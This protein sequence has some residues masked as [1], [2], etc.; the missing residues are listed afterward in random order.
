MSTLDGGEGDPGIA[1]AV[2]DSLSE[3]CQV[4]GFDWSYLYVNE[5]AARH[6]RTTRAELIGKTMM[7]C[8]PGIEEMPVFDL[9]RRCMSGRTA[10]R[11]DEEFSFADGSKRWFDLRVV[12]VP[13]GIYIL[14]IDVTARRQAELSLVE[15]ERM[16][17]GLFEAAPDGILVAERD[18]TILMANPE[19]E[20]MFAS[21]EGSLVGRS[22]ESLLPVPS[23][24]AHAEHR[25]QFFASPQMRRMRKGR[26]LA[27][28]RGDGSSFP[29]NV[30]LG[31]YSYQSRD[32]AVAVVRDI[33]EQKQLAEK[34]QRSEEQL[35]QAQKMEAIG[36]LA[37]GV[38]HDFNNLLSVILSYSYLLARDL[39]ADD[40][41]R[42][43]LDEIRRAGERAADLTRQLLAFGRKQILEPRPISLHGI[44]ASI[45][46]M[47]RRILGEDI[48]LTVI[49]DPAPAIVNV[50]PGQMEQV[51]LNLAVNSR[52]AMPQGGK[53]TIEIRSVELDREYIAGHFGI[54]PGPHVMLAV[55]D[56]GT[57]MTPEV[58]AR[59]F[60]PFFTTKGRGTGLGLSTV[61][62]I[63][64]QSGGDI[65]V[66]SEP[67]NG[68]TFKIYLPLIGAEAAALAGSPPAPRA[69]MAQETILLVEDEEQV[70]ILVRNI[71]RRQGYQVLDA[72]DAASALQLCE[73]HADEI[74][75]LLTD[76]VMPGMSGRQLAERLQARRPGLRVLFM[77]GYTDDAIV[78]H[79]VLDAGVMFIQKP[80]RPDALV[81]KIREVLDGQ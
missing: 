24:D 50:D 34:L 70:R 22:I 66:Y 18:G 73:N 68:T 25:A 13:Q 40:P 78:H 28:V 69:R 41:T 74:G 43:E 33:S 38:A 47:L 23:R 44:V 61:F 72:A 48:A 11:M 2:L 14:S 81:R 27:A 17:R 46:R 21:P 75:L 77:S 5:A 7:E 35:R 8:Y 29:V 19:A 49:A 51:L 56:T 45:E 32:A 3:G 62:G 55:S 63:V 64:K 31:A 1:R 65:W 58:K 30:T 71:L 76:V 10:E 15:S 79:G 9:L 59:L 12:P 4:I 57:G 54:E 20:R 37:G 60:E 53:L 67:G 16:L 39:P 80:I 36:A 52:D 6:G 26:E 42:V